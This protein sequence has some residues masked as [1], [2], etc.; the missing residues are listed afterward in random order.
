MIFNIEGIKIT[1]SI[2]NRHATCVA[3][4]P[5]CSKSFV[6]N[7]GVVLEMEEVCNRLEADIGYHMIDTLKGCSAAKV[8]DHNEYYPSGADA[9]SCITAFNED[10][11]E[12]CTIRKTKIEDIKEKIHDMVAAKE[13][14]AKSQLALEKLL[15]KLEQRNEE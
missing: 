14:L 3:L 7:T 2:E 4:C 9:W 10:D 15:Y 12:V 1:A 5:I 11:E 6:L 8:F 13:R